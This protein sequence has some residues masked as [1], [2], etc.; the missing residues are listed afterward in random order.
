MKEVKKKAYLTRISLE[1]CAMFMSHYLNIGKKKI[2]RYYWSD[3]M[4]IVTTY[5]NEKQ[6][7]PSILHSFNC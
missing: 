6:F 7:V 4:L 3:N 1:L 2:S 5:N